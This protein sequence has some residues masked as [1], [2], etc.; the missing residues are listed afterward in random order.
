[1]RLRGICLGL[2]LPIVSCYGASQAIFAPDLNQWTLT[3]GLIRAVFQ[4][5]PE[6]YFL[7]SE[8]SDLQSGDH[9]TASAKR[10]TSP[11]RLQADAD[12][13]DANT[14]FQFVSQSTQSITAPAGTRQYI[15]LQDLNHAAQITVIFEIYDNQPILR[16][17]LR[18][19]NLKPVSLAPWKVRPAEA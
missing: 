8:I 5:T 14:P 6:G 1:M 12:L 18:Y 13:F 17:S 16:Y 2:L 4:L 9:W 3:N 10:P 15:V 19:K 7:T 11:V